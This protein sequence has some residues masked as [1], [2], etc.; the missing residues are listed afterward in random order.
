MFD[1][2][3]FTILDDPNFKEDAV[4]EELIVPILNRLGY[5]ATGEHRIIRSKP[6]VHPFV[7][8][9]TKNY[10][11]NIIPD[12]LLA[13]SGTIKW[14]L[15]A[16]APPEDILTGKHVEQAYS[17]AIHK[18]VRVPIY[19]LCNGH[20]LAVFYISHVEPV[21]HERL[22]VIDSQWEKVRNILCPMAFVD[23]EQIEFF[24]DFGLTMLR[25][26]GAVFERIWLP[27][28]PI[29]YLGKTSDD[30]YT[31]STQFDIGTEYC[32]TF[33]LNPAMYQVL[34]DGLAEATR[35]EVTAALSHM[36]YYVLFEE[37]HPAVAITAKLEA[38][39][40]ANAREEFVPFKVLDIQ[41]SQ[42]TAA[43]MLKIAPYET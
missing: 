12:Y 15:D 3:D 8:I 23:P 18:D 39:I 19:G 16:K 26:G 35:R 33:D 42:F 31:I 5:S 4:R 32:G 2:F 40:I 38:N 36:P 43:D 29:Y 34:L 6:L 7:Y 14:V 21:L 13:V 11:V 28:V 24:P 41:P 22:D 9:G 17:Y 20:E 1:H 27:W 30:M 25:L 37:N 10:K